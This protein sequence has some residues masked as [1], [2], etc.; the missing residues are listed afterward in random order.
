MVGSDIE[1]DGDIGL[2]VI[3]V[4]E[5]ERGK[6]DDIYL[7]G[8]AGHLKGQT[9][10]YVS[11]EANVEAGIVQDMV[12]QHR[13]CRF[14]VASRDTDHFRIGVAAGEL[15]L[16]DD[17]DRPVGNS[18]DHR[19]R[20]GYA[21]AF[22]HY[23]GVENLFGSV[24]SLFPFYPFGVE[25]GGIARRHSA[26]VGKEHFHPFVFAENCGAYTAFSSAEHYEF[27][28]LLF[29]VIHLLFIVF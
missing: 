8:L 18:S 17:G 15:Y 9:A 16:R 11:C 3:H 4:F 7:V 25:H 5:L 29:V 20:R 21:G 27:L 12:G 26:H 1:H 22:H 10:A 2:E 19:C 28:S 13:S 23:V 24:V 14:A 6:L